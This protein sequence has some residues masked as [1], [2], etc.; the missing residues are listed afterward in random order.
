[1]DMHHAFSK[2]EEWKAAHETEVEFIDMARA[3]RLLAL[4]LGHEPEALI[5]FMAERGLQAALGVMSELA[6]ANVQA[7][8][9]RHKA[10]LPRA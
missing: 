2:A 5:D 7:E 8:Y 6:G 1:M 4:D 9:L 3:L 10:A